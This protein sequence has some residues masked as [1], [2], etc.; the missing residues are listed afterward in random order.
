M[1]DAM[2]GGVAATPDVP[3]RSLGASAS[4]AFVG[5]Q[6]FVTAR[7]DANESKHGQVRAACLGLLVARTRS[8]GGLRAASRTLAFLWTAPGQSS[9]AASGAGRPLVV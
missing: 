4:G 9:A 6:W 2:S 3:R 1:A 8:L 5:C 7:I